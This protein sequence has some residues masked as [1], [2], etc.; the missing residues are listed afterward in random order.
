MGHSAVRQNEAYVLICAKKEGSGT[1][2]GR[3]AAH[4][5]MKKVQ[6]FG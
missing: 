6:I 2:K 4:R 5:K 3:K 1:S